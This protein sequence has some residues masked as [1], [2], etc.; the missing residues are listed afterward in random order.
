[1]IPEVSIIIPCRNEEKFIGSLLNDLLRQT[2][3]V[4]KM[5]VLVVDGLSKDG[6]RKIVSDFSQQHVFIRLLDN[7]SLTVPYALNIGIEQSRARTIMI[8][9]AH[10]R[11][12]VNYVNHLFTALYEN[13]A[14]NVGGLMET[15]AANN[16]SQAVAIAL[17]MSSRFG[18]GNAHYRIGAKSIR[19]VD[20][21]PFGCYRKDVFNRLGMFDTSLTRNQD[22]EFNG[23]LKNAGGKILLIPSV[24]F[25]YFARP[26]LIKTAL[27]FYQYGLFKPLVNIKL[28][29]P[30][31]L[32]QFAPPA[33]VLFFTIMIIASLFSFIGC[34][35][36]L[37][38]VLG[39]LLSLY[40]VAFSIPEAK[41]ATKHWLAF[42]FPTIHFSY[43]AGY[44]VGVLRFTILREHKTQ[45]TQLP[46][47][48][49]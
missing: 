30:A 39:Y 20:T 37:A 24:N 23:R 6:T 4:E 42:T 12:P 46:K 47:S 34:M 13:N 9:G 1:M 19:E 36:L 22:D 15:I 7:T 21:T 26:T 16:S 17:A 18:V 8:M 48:S 32:R 38:A 5:E 44:L 2:F 40:T 41:T 10:S 49:R 29:K 14:D 27:M 11:Y 28:G 35:L 3:G 43:G 45:I 25:Q 31:T 33:L